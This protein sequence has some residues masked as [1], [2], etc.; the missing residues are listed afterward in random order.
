MLVMGDFTNGLPRLEW[1]W[2]L[3]EKSP[4]AFAA[5]LWRGE[6]LRG[7]T[8][9]LHAEQGFGDSL[10]PKASGRLISGQCR[11]KAG[12]GWPA[13]TT[14]YG[15][16]ARRAARRSSARGTSMTTRPPPAATSGA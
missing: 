8:I 12:S 5:P 1:R 7:K 3:P 13:A 4:R 11:S 2:R 9:R 10:M 6:R 15:P 14:V 16:P